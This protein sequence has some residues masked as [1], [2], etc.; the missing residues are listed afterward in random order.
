MI[1]KLL[2]EIDARVKKIKIVA[3]QPQIN[4]QVSFFI[5]LGN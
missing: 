1:C 3:K 4:E 2:G 5:F